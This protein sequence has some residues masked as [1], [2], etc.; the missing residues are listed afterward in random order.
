[1]WNVEAGKEK[2]SEKLIFL[3][4]LGNKL[5][6][7]LLSLKINF[8]ILNRKR[9]FNNEAPENTGIHLLTFFGSQ[10]VYNLYQ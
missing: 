5:F 8:I 9:K 1:M 3:L 2:L 6:V 4:L 7:V 10:L